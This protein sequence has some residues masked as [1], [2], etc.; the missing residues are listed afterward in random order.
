MLQQRY[1]MC[2]FRRVDVTHFVQRTRRRLATSGWFGCATGFWVLG[3]RVSMRQLGIDQDDRVD[4]FS[5]P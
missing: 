3:V 5:F 1:V 4:M 2:R